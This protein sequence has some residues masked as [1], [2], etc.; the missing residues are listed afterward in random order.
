MGSQT[1]WNSRELVKPATGL[2]HVGKR[3]ALY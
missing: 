2:E 3:D 1:I